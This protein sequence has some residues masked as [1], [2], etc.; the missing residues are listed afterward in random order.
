[1]N[2]DKLTNRWYMVAPHQSTKN[3]ACTCDVKAV[4]ENDKATCPQC[5]R[6]WSLKG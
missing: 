2:N 3:M 5:N 4:F 6:Q 1:M